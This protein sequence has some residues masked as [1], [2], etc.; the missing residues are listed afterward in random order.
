MGF[1]TDSTVACRLCGRPNSFITA[2]Y[3]TSLGWP[4][5]D[6]RPPETTRSNL[7]Y[8]IQRCPSCGYC[9]PDL[10]LGRLQT[11]AFISSNLY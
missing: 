6:T 5:L 11:A 1:L 8:W 10:S 7:P 3:S 4:D 9:A 2:S